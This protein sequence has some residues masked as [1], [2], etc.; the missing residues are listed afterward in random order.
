MRIALGL[1]LLAAGES[2]A[3]AEEAILDTARPFVADAV[4]REL[5]LRSAIGWP[6]FQEGIAGG[7]V[8]RFDPDGYARF[9]LDQRLG[10]DAWEV[11]CVPAPVDCTG[12]RAP[13]PVLL[14]VDPAGRI[15][16]ALEGAAADR[17][18]RLDAGEGDARTLAQLVAAE[19]GA[20][21]TAATVLLPEPEGEAIPIDGLPVV[22]AYIRWAEAGQPEDLRLDAPVPRPIGEPVAEA[23]A[24]DAPAAAPAAAEAPPAK[25]DEAT[26]VPPPAAAD[27]PADADAVTDAAAETVMATGPGDTVE[28]A[29]AAEPAEAAAAP[30]AEAA[31]EDAPEV[32]EAPAPVVATDESN[33]EVAPEPPPVAAAPPAEP[34]AAETTAT[35]E[36][37]AASEPAATGDAEAAP[38]VEV[39]EVAE[40]NA[41]ALDA[42]AAPSTTVTPQA[43]PAVADLP[44]ATPLAEAPAEGAAAPAPASPPAAAAPSEPAAPAAAQAA[45]A[46]PAE[47]V[48]PATSA[49]AEA[50]PPVEAVAEGNAGAVDAVAAAATTVAPPADPG[51]ADL[52]AA[53]PTEVAA[54]PVSPTPP[55]AP[56]PTEA[57]ARPAQET[58]TAAPAEPPPPPAAEAPAA[59]PAAVAPAAIVAPSIPEPAPAAPEPAAPAAPPA[60]VVAALSAPPAATVTERAMAPPEPSSATAAAVATLA[61]A[62]G[63]SEAAAAM[64][65]VQLQDAGPAS[66]DTLAACPAGQLPP[67]PLSQPIE[68]LRGLVGVHL[69]TDF[70][71]EPDELKGQL[72]PAV[73]T[74]AEER[75][76]AAGIRLLDAEEVETVPGK[77]RLELYLTRGD[78]L[79]GCPFRIWMSLRQEIALARN[80]EVRLLS[81]TWGDGGPA[82]DG[83]YTGTELE[84]FTYH[85]ERFVAAWQEAQQPKPPAEPSPAP[86]ATPAAPAEQAPAPL[87]VA[88]ATPDPA[89]AAPGATRAPRELDDAQI[90]GIQ[91][92]LKEFGYDPGPTD[93]IMGPRTLRAIQAFERDNG[94]PVTGQP[95][96]AVLDR[97]LPRPVEAT[98]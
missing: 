38:P 31:A 15:G 24:E 79:L 80:T 8:Y 48:P 91:A 65:P 17:R 60:T 1:L 7:W 72:R 76:K 69:V 12:R 47:P 40:G 54:A 78:A 58:R 30:S 16:L 85:I 87:P 71:T 34:T 57:A 36:S 98:P 96:G 63:P 88:A 44:G 5:F 46:A 26:D 74:M 52:P 11:R 77:P 32:A 19:D 66:P 92:R 14:S 29:A 94:L 3:L 6:I 59:A 35:A 49:E 93:G 23:P 56:A 73:R 20:A 55:V 68:S 22:A 21:L 42:R 51:V 90:A 70:L 33:A 9:G 27:A 67:A 89:P 84:T 18:Y 75:L 2:P 64:T 37:P 13:T 43:D 45:T 61:A 41:G 62:A 97:L 82:R 39:A 95:A 10:E 50:A 83:G 53:T 28:A 86:A 81:G 4:E 25:A